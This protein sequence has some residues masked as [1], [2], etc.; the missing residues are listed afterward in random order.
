MS[1]A[2]YFIENDVDPSTMNYNDRNYG[3]LNEYD[4]ASDADDTPNAFI[5]DRFLNNSVN[6]EY[7]D[8]DNG[9]TY[10]WEVYQLDLFSEDYSSEVRVSFAYI[11]FY[12]CRSLNCKRNTFFRNAA[13]SYDIVCVMH[14]GL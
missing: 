12:A 6:N 2:E 11:S 9:K 13:I 4:D 10:N 7:G 1:L 14:K 3:P 5:I 8:N